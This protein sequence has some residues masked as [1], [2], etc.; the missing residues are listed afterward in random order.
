MSRRPGSNRNGACGRPAVSSRSGA[1]RPAPTGSAWS[2]PPPDRAPATAPRCRGSSGDSGG[3]TRRLGGSAS[4]R[5]GGPRNQPSTG[6][7]ASRQSRSG[8]SAT[9][10]SEAHMPPAGSTRG[11]RQKFCDT[12]DDADHDGCDLD[13]VAFVLGNR[14]RR[15]V[16]PPALSTDLAELLTGWALGEPGEHV[17]DGPKPPRWLLD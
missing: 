6:A 15:L 11:K 9:S 16:C 13:K 3:T 12:P 2:G 1:H 4:L 8:S 17:T 7:S 10:G 14:R 5:N